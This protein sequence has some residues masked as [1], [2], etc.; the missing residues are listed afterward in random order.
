MK[1]TMSLFLIVCVLF[2]LVACDKSQ[3]AS[4]QGNNAGQQSAQQATQKP[5]QKVTPK[6]TQKP[7]PEPCD[8]YYT[9]EVTV[10]ATCAKTGTKK[11][12]CLYCDHSYTEPVAK[13]TSHNWEYATCTK[14]DTC[15][16]CGK[17]DGKA[18]G[19]NYYSDGECS[20]CGQMNPTVTNALAKCKLTMPSLPK[21]VSYYR[22]NGSKGT[23]VKV[24]NIKYEFDC[25]NDGYVSLKVYFSGEKTYDYQGS[26]QSSSCY[27]GWKLYA[28]DGSVI[29]DGT[30]YTPALKVG[31]T[32]SNKETTVLYSSDKGEAGTYKLEI[33][34]TN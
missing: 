24:T 8:H 16:V 11:Y 34:D 6:P 1:K 25:N 17:T 3:P 12:T 29:D 15:K 18:K 4:N 28:P 22:Y 20:R 2:Y 10:E 14:P 32:F 21:T 26:G 19:H 31:E 9:S 27:I 5:T 30:F 7:T 23:S 13:K 33:L